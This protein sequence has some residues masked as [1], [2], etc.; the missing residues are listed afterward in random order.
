MP[1]DDDLVRALYEGPFEQPLWSSFVSLLRARTGA[2]YVGLIFRPLGQ[3]Q[4]VELFSEE[5]PSVHMR[6]LMA[7]QVVPD[8]LP[9]RNMREGRVY[10]LEEMIDPGQPAYRSYQDDLIIPQGLTNVLAVRVREISG[11]DAWLFCSGNKHMKSSTCVMMN[12]LVPHL[13]IALRSCIALERER[14]RSQVTSETFQR[15]NFGWLTLDEHVR[16][17]DMTPHLEQFFDRST[18]IRRGRHNRLMPASPTI[19]RE[20]KGLV[21]QFAGDTEARPRAINLSRDPQIDMLLRPI[22]DRSLSTSS[23]PVAIAY[24]SSD[25]LS[26]ADRCDQ[27]VDLFGLLPSEARLAWAI[28]QGMSISEAANELGLTIETARSYS[29]RIYAKIGARGQAELV[30]NIL[31]SILALT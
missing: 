28:A 19:D 24:I 18:V 12:A 29:K 15:L 31:T 14:F 1:D 4:T 5:L 13:K 7:R 6:D 20:L 26:L 8:P 2:L 21:R 23:V 30:R 9:Y 11:I 22:R 3:D 10:S 25:R 16:I 27:L 17:V